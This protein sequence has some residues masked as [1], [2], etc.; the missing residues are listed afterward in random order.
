MLICLYL[1]EQPSESA[2][3]CLF[4]SWRVRAIGVLN[5]QIIWNAWT[6][7]LPSEEFLLEL[8]LRGN[9]LAVL[10]RFA[11]RW[12]LIGVTSRRTL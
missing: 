4:V 9:L 1:L 11:A 3:Y 6:Q 7:L 12:D 2:H 10:V 8:L 5:L